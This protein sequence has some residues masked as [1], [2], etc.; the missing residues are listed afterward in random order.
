[1]GKG[2][3]GPVGGEAGPTGSACSRG[4]GKRK[5][6]AGLNACG[7]K[8]KGERERKK[9]FCLFFKFSFQIRFSNIE[10]KTMHSNHD[11]QALIIS[12]LF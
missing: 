1:M 10:T 2:G 4:E 11:A 9:G 6:P 3:D 8:V 7:L 5:R 12:K